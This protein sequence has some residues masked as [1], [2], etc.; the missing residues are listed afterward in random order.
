MRAWGDWPALF[1]AKSTRE[2][3]LGQVSWLTAVLNGRLQWRDR[4]RFS[5]PSLLC[6]LLP[7]AGEPPEPINCRERGYVARREVSTRRLRHAARTV[8]RSCAY[9]PRRRPNGARPRTSGPR[10]APG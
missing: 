3:R 9:R 7:A 6:P 1:L 10:D 8:R 2:K 5:R 4:G